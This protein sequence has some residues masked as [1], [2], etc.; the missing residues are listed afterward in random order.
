MFCRLGS[1]LRGRNPSRQQRRSFQ[2]STHTLINRASRPRPKKDS[3]AT[4]GKRKIEQFLLRR[5]SRAC[6]ATSRALQYLAPPMC[7][8]TNVCVTSS[9]GKGLTSAAI[10]YLHGRIKFGGGERVVEAKIQ[11]PQ[12]PGNQMVSGMTIGLPDSPPLALVPDYASSRPHPPTWP[13]SPLELLEV[14]R[15]LLLRAF[16]ARLVMVKLMSP[17]SSSDKPSSL[18][19]SAD[20]CEQVHNTRHP[21]DTAQLRKQRVMRK[22]CRAG[23]LHTLQ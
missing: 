8:N 20:T 16:S 22:A 5:H 2:Y 10:I 4:G 11:R 3:P 6:T 15:T 9:P 19:I 7:S 18:I 12:M 1:S 14:R 13:T 17:S 23:I 21:R